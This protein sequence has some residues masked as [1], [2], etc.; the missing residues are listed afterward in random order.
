MNIS[1]FVVTPPRIGQASQSPSPAPE[2][3]SQI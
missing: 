2:K 1:S 3:L